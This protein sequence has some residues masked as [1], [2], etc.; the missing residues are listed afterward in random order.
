[1][2]VIDFLPDKYHE[3]KEQRRTCYW[4]VIV[5]LSFSGLLAVAWAGEYGIQLSYEHQLA[6]VRD[7]YRTALVQSQQ[8]TKL[9]QDLKPWEAKAELWTYLRHPW[10]RSQI[11]HQILETLPS[12]ITLSRV[13]SERESI[14][15]EAGQSI[16]PQRTPDEIKAEEAK[17]MPAERDLGRLRTEMDSTQ[18]IITL[19]GLTEDNISLHAY[20]GRLASQGLFARCELSSLESGDKKHPGIS[21]FSARLIV[22]PGYGQPGSESLLAAGQARS[23][24]SP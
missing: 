15:P 1:M 19:E 5:L 16:A 8:L 17:K 4:R 20:L 9:E 14:A 6:E 11:L 12:E 3:A 13:Y 2:Q 10:P 18:L 7:L 22:K 21:K 24:G 23:G